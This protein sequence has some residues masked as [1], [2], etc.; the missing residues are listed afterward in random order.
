M[1]PS[2][3]WIYHNV[4][5]R[6][7]RE[8]TWSQSWD[9][10]S[11]AKIHIYNHMKSV[12]LPCCR[13]APKWYQNEQRLFCD[14][15]I[16]SAWTSDLFL[17]KDGHQKWLV[18]HVDN[19]SVHTSWVSTSWLEEHDMRRMLHPPSL[20]AWFDFLWLLLAFYIER[21]LKMIQ[22]CQEDRSFECLQELSGI[23]TTINWI[24]FFGLECNGFKK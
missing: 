7:C 13:Q 12:R 23:S 3:S 6:F 15:N 5:W 21:K 20:L 11:R 2:F 16:K 4:A 8:I 14:K 19:C 24:G 22:I 18:T 10:I 1:T 17:R 9:M